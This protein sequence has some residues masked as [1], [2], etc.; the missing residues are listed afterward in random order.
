MHIKRKDVAN[1]AGVSEQTVSYVMNNSRKFSQDVVDR[2]NK[3]IETLNYHPDMIARSLVKKET[4]TVAIVVRN[5][6]NPI[7]PAI[8]RG[9]QE[10]AF[11]CGYSVYIIDMDE[12]CDMESRV[13]DLLSRRVDGVYVSLMYENSL[14]DILQRFVDGGIK[15]VLG[16]AIN[17]NK[18]NLP[19]VE[20]DMDNGM[21]KIV[22]YLKRKGHE[23]IV[24]LNGLDPERGGDDRCGAFVDE[25][26]KQFG[27]EPMMINNVAPYATTV[28][29]GK[30]LADRLVQSKFPYTAVVTTNDLM[31]YGVIDYLKALGMCVPADVSVVG[32]DDILY[33]KYIDPPLTTLG[34]DYKFLGR[35]IFS[36]LYEE[37]KG[38]AV[39]SSRI[40]AH[41]VERG[42]VLDLSEQTTKI[43][44]ARSLR[45]NK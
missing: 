26:R 29:V 22:R 19:I 6:A 2:V 45:E 23:N 14:N 37:M 20:V 1:L 7:F 28:E 44:K 4:Y 21:R 32:I 3:A 30:S 24:Y 31:A 11:E 40:E 16:N 41:I 18:Y 25:Y 17:V 9:F 35:K 34:Y 43:M 5:I 33:S 15:I 12:N 13:G 8:I 36:T 27:K 10:K 38:N 42:T 39:V